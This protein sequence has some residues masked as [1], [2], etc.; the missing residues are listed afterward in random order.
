[1]NIKIIIVFT[2]RAVPG[3]RYSSVTLLLVVV[4]L[5][6]HYTVAHCYRYNLA[7]GREKRRMSPVHA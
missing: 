7:R 1:M 6:L 5:T 4:G 3:T 2:N